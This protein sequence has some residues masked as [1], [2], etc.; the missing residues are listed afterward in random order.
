MKRRNGMYIYK[1][2]YRFNG[3]ESESDIAEGDYDFGARIYDGRLGRW[4]SCDP[5]Q[6]KYA[7]FGPY[8]F[9]A[10]MPLIAVDPDG[11]VVIISG[12]P[13]FKEKTFQHLQKLTNE[14]LVMLP[15]GMVVTEKIFNQMLNNSN[16]LV[17]Q[18]VKIGTADNANKKRYGTKNVNSLI[19]SEKT[20]TVV[21]SKDDGNHTDTDQP[22]DERAARKGKPANMTVFYNPNK[23]TGGLNTKGNR[24]RSPWIGLFHELKHAL[25][26]FKGIFYKGEYNLKTGKRIPHPAQY[27]DPDGKKADGSSRYQLPEEVRTRKE[28][29]IV[30]E[31]QGEADRVIPK[32][33]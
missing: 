1:Y 33:K 26:G 24:K 21:E 17:G 25:H 32:K 27:I 22:E 6:E 9:V 13:E 14:N 31:E 23:M 28:E 15:D 8:V 11:K 19:T 4:L 7:E 12:S 16:D 2:R 29:N 3:K 5:L 30:R 18:T 20:V 10:N